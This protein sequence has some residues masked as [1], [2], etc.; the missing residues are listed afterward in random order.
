MP[1]RIRL[2]LWYLL[3]LTIVLASVAAGVYEFVSNE[4]RQSVDRVLRER[5]DAFARAYAGEAHEQP[6]D[7]AMREVARDYERGNADIFVYAG[8]DKLLERSPMRLLR[9]A[10]ART[11]PEI[12]S[13]IQRAVAGRATNVTI[14]HV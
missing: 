6:G 14:D 13:A 11:I 5:A 9:V 1:I 7:E 4:E 12:R 3:I 8:P 2:T 10:D